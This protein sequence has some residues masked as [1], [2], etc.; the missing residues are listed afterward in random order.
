MRSGR[1]GT[2]ARLRDT[3]DGVAPDDFHVMGWVVAGLPTVCGSGFVLTRGMELALVLLLCRM[4]CRA[5]PTECAGSYP[6]A[7]WLYAALQRLV[8]SP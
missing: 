3:S 5:G 6:S 8:A 4:L 7:D 2:L 1:K